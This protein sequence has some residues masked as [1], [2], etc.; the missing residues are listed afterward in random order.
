MG[1]SSGEWTEEEVNK[2]RGLVHSLILAV[3]G[4]GF[5]IVNQDPNKACLSCKD[6]HELLH[7]MEELGY[8]HEEDK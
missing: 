5:A 8:V 7:R 2:F 1:T 3:N 4:A 6:A